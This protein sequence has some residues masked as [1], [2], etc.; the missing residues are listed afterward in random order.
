VDHHILHEL[1]QQYNIRDYWVFGLGSLS[2]IVEYLRLAPSNGPN[3][4]VVSHPLT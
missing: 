1:V 4:V 2:D 3:K